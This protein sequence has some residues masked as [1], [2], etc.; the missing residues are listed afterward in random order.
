MESTVEK[1]REQRIRER[2][3]RSWEEEGRPKGKHEEHWERAAREFDE[4]DDGSAAD[5]A[6]EP[7][8]KGEKQKE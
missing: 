4:D 1:D 3:Y 7:D 2:A 6:T 8:E 5:D